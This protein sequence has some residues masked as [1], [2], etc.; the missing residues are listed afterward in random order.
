MT[1]VEHGGKWDQQQQWLAKAALRPSGGELQLMRMQTARC[2]LLMQGALLIRALRVVGLVVVVIAGSS[3]LAERVALAHEELAAEALSQLYTVTVRRTS[4]NPWN[5]THSYEL[6]DSQADLLLKTPFL[7]LQQLGALDLRN[8]SGRLA[9]RA[10]LSFVKNQQ[11]P[12]QGPDPELEAFFGF[13]KL[14]TGF[15]LQE[16]VGG[17]AGPSQ[18]PSTPQAFYNPFASSARLQTTRQVFE[19]NFLAGG[20]VEGASGDARGGTQKML[21]AIERKVLPRPLRG[22]GGGGVQIKFFKQLAGGEDDQQEVAAISCRK[23]TC[24]FYS[25]MPETLRPGFL[26]FF[27]QDQFEHHFNQSLQMSLKNSVN[28]SLSY[29]KLSTMLDTILTLTDWDSQLLRYWVLGKLMV[30]AGP[31]AAIIFADPP[32]R[33]G[34]L[35][36][37]RALWRLGEPVVDVGPRADFNNLVAFFMGG[38]GS[39]AIAMLTME[40]VRQSLEREGN[41]QLSRDILEFME[42]GSRNLPKSRRRK[43]I[44]T[45]LTAAF[46]Y[47]FYRTV[48]ASHFLARSRRADPAAGPSRYVGYFRPILALADLTLEERGIRPGHDEVDFDEAWPCPICRKPVYVEPAEGQPAPAV[49]QMRTNLVRLNCGMGRN[50][51]VLCRGC[52]ETELDRLSDL[53]RPP[54]CPLCTRPL[55]RMHAAVPPP[56]HLHP[57]LRARDFG[58]V[59][60]DVGRSLLR[61]AERSAAWTNRFLLRAFNLR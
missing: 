59:V 34:A 23:G 21:I 41:T 37:A 52:I 57:G 16:A 12:P 7:P 3:L 60:Q 22:G 11:D 8:F 50:E 13:G 1:S 29:F 43:L 58:A 31:V 33:Q 36:L 30:V 18:S 35:V 46:G 38:V 49:P 61:R 15:T 47:E 53:M 17:S 45:A 5:M 42:S 51:H 40:E 48:V 39:T 27:L 44:G 28:R 24:Q 2:R 54:A 14:L 19:M 55:V 56:P 4:Y 9:E 25:L 26:F 32:R 10:R 6:H 20:E